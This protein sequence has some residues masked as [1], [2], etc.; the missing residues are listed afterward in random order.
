MPFYCSTNT[1]AK[2]SGKAHIA[3]MK[4][5]LSVFPHICK[6]CYV[7]L[8]ILEAPVFYLLV[9]TEQQMPPQQKYY[10]GKW[11]KNYITTEC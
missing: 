5:H 4:A 7:G 3:V 2:I 10:Y 1:S 9:S 8:Q 6:D 11:V